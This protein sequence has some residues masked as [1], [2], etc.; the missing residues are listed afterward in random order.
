MSEYAPPPPPNMYQSPGPD[1][2]PTSGL[3]VT[4]M[5]LGI[6]FLCLGPLALLPLILGIIGISTTGANGKK[7]GQGFAIAGTAL[8]GVGLMG[9]CLSIGIFLPALGKA[10]MAAQQLLSEAQ[11]NQ[12]VVACEN[13]AI[14]N[15][16]QY[17][18][19]ETWEEDLYGYLG[20][21]LDEAMVSPRED[22]DGDGVSYIYLGGAYPEDPSHMLFYE[23]PKHYPRLGVLVGFVDSETE[24]IP[25][26]IFEQMLA[27]QLSEAEAQP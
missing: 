5:V 2:R 10:R 12:L 24:I 1:T 13:Y 22:E 4:S 20:I 21:P 11:L 19:V 27:E 18:P 15:N 3:A 17:P 7:Q 16:N 9:S 26:D 23:D 14:D 6:L 25:F 8:G